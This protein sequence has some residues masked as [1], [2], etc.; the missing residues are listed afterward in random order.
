MQGISLPPCVLLC[1]IR[2][3]L[4]V[5]LEAKVEVR[6]KEK[7]P[8]RTVQGHQFQAKMVFVKVGLL[9]NRRVGEYWSHYMDHL[10]RLWIW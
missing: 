8:T 2:L 3:K 9:I 7:L 6:R 1:L 10:D 4:K 5:L